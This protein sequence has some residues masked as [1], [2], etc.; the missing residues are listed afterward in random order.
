MEGSEQFHIHT[1]SHSNGSPGWASASFKSFLHPSQ[2]R[3]TTVQFLHPSF[4]VSSFT[5]SS[6][7]SLD[8]STLYTR[9]RTH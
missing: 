4:A 6:Q 5:P 7:R 3:A 1:V 2:F 9:K 8:T